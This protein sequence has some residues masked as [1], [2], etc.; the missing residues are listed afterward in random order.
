MKTL[1][2]LNMPRTAEV[3]VSV[4]GLR[5]PR[6][7]MHRCSACTTTITP[8]GSRRR[9]SASAI[10]VVSRSCTCGRRAYRST[11]RA[12]LDSPVIR[13]SSPGM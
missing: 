8:R 3:I 10:W 7:A 4:P 11:S 2:E 9:T 13:P 6:M 12:S 5:T 1:A